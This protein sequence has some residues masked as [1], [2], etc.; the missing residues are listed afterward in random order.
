M[1]LQVAYRTEPCAGFVR[2]GDAVV[3]RAT[4]GRDMLAVVDALGHGPAAAVVADLAS[5]YLNYVADDADAGAI[6]DGL[7]KALRGSRGAQGLVCVRV[8]RH[9]QGCGVGNVDMR[10]IGAEVPVTLTPGILGNGIRNRRLFEGELV[11][12]AR[13]AIF[14][15]GISFRTS[16]RDVAHLSTDLA[17]SELFRRHRRSHDDASLLIAEAGPAAGAS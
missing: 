3:V 8:G 15:D 16:L 4:D 11:E 14:S 10:C 13:L 5:D 1:R 7:D 12:G 6:I 17:C 2:N 9:V